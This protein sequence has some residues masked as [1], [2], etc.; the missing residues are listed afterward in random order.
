[1]SIFV[2][3]HSNLVKNQKY[4]YDIVGV[5]LLKFESGVLGRVTNEAIVST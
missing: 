5:L 2:I 1:M 4:I 3:G